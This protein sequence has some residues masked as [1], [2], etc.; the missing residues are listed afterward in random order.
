M[1]WESWWE[2]GEGA[3]VQGDRL[4]R[5]R[6]ECP[7]CLR[8]GNFRIEYQS[9]LQHGSTNKI[10]NFEVLKC[11]ECVMSCFVMWSASTMGGL[12]GHH[13]Y[14][15]FPN[16]LKTD[17]K[18]PQHW[19]SQ[20]GSAWEQAHKAIGTKS[21][22]AA[23]AMAGRALQAATRGHFKAKPGKLKSE[24]DELGERGILPTPMMEWAHEI[25]LLRNVGAHPDEEGIAVDAKDA[26]D[27]VEFM[28]YFLVYALNLP[29]QIADYKKRRAEKGGV[30]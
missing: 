20:I 5:S 21:W 23:A 30:M 14:V 10:M 25:R 28:D 2:L 9:A 24:I 1:V 16:S 19:P 15:V 12:H 29:R 13:G 26:R 3:G 4:Y 7:H 8:R 11:N 18:A 27:I 22:D 6:I 17:R